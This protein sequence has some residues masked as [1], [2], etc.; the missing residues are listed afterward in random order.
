[1]VPWLRGCKRSLVGVGKMLPKDLGTYSL[2]LWV[3][4][5]PCEL[6]SGPEYS[7]GTA[8]A[9]DSSYSWL[10]EVERVM[11]SWLVPR[12]SWVAVVVPEFGVV[13]GGSP[14]AEAKASLVV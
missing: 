14:F 11:L 10:A 4:E 7:L 9:V 2:R 5:V 12:C 8:V 1:M 13:H 6:G 3:G